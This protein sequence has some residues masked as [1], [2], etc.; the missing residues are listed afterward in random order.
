MAGK[1]LVASKNRLTA[2]LIQTALK[3][4]GHQI[5]IAPNGVAVVDLALDHKPNA[6]F[7]GV[8]LTGLSGIETARA[9]RALALTEN[10]PIIFLAENAD[11]AQICID[12]ELIWIG[13]PPQVIE[14]MGHKSEA[15]RNMQAAG[16]PVIPGSDGPVAGVAECRVIF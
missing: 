8:A 13:P 16:C 11:F 6:I 10:V 14:K 15:K 9:L 1:F 7:I 4:D 3:A 5:I 12:H 2:N